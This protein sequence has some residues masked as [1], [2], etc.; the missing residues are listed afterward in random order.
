MSDP[1]LPVVNNT[2]ASWA[3][4]R[5]KITGDSFEFQ[6]RALKS[7]KFADGVD[8][9]T[10]YGEG[11]NPLGDTT[12]IYKTEDVTVEYWLDAA[13]EFLRRLK[14]VNERTSLVYFS[15][16]GDW[17]IPGGKLHSVNIGGC[18]II[19]R[20]VDAESGTA[21]GHFMPFKVHCTSIAFDGTYLLGGPDE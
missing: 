10:I 9:E 14:A 17:E 12:G 1:Q 16:F 13:G 21:A 15:I 7:L 11:P 18:R 3:D 20:S 19:G 6:T 2:M 4:L 8:V 5:T